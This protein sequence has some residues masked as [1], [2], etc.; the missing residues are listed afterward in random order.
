MKNP[1][2]SSADSGFTFVETLVCIFIMALLA[3][4]ITPL[5]IG[6]IRSY[7]H[8]AEAEHHKRT[9][10]KAHDVFRSECNNTLPPPWA[11][12]GSLAKDEGR[13][14]SIAYR[15]GK[16]ESLWNIRIDEGTIQIRTESETTVFSASEASAGL[17]MYEGKIIGMELHFKAL[18]LKW[19][20]REYFGASGS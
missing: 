9:I 13:Q 15:N 16:R 10:A 5:A 6:S 11:P 19:T 7:G 20:W 2:K 14:I 3:S 18:G 8:I 17:L 1:G 12:I 4:I